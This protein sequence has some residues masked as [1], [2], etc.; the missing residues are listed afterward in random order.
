MPGPDQWDDII[1]ATGTA[2]AAIVLAFVGWQA[3]EVTKLRSRV[4]AL[5]EQQAADQSRFRDAVRFIRALL[6]HVQELTVLLAHHA[7]GQ[8]PTSAPPAIPDS[9]RDEV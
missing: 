2:I 4:A 8:P 3:R 6:T 5:E 9:I 1:S 7:P